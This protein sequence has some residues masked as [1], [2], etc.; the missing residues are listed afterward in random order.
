MG[1]NESVGAPLPPQDN[2]LPKWYKI[3]AKAFGTVGSSIA[4]VLGAVACITIT[5]MC[6]VAGITLMTISFI[7][8]I[9]EAP[10]CC[11]C[12]EFAQKCSNFT[13]ARPHWQKAISYGVLSVFPV[14][15]C[16][17]ITTIFGCGLI[18]VTA[19]VYGMMALGKKAD[20][21]TMRAQAINSKDV[22]MQAQLIQ[23]D[24][25]QTTEPQ[26]S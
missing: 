6:L 3:A 26:N 7:I 14:L 1:Q 24:S 25:L 4:F 9:V 23:N 22:E 5:P 20:R 13:D 11:P 21:E 15:M 16:A 2:D 17:E 12:I 8:M 18:F 10:C 19:A